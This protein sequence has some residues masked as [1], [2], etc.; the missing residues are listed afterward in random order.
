MSRSASLLPGR[1][2]GRGCVRQPPTLA[3]NR[4]QCSRCRESTR[5]FLSSESGERR[6]LDACTSSRNSV[7]TYKINSCKMK[8]L[9]QMIERGRRRPSS[10]LHVRRRNLESCMCGTVVESVLHHD[11]LAVCR[12]VLMCI[13]VCVSSET[14]QASEACARHRA[15][16]FGRVPPREAMHGVAQE[17]QG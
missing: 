16:D 1:R 8:P 9:L 7:L 17:R 2:P 10:L 11:R 3:F 13:W 4:A 12:H 14:W 15:R 5:H 6:E